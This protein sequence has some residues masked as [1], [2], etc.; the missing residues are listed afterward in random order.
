MPGE[1]MAG[2]RDDRNVARPLVHLQAPGCFPAIHARQRQVHQ[3]DVGKE[4]DRFLDRLETVRRFGDAISGKLQIR[5]VH[6][7]RILVVLD[8]K[9][10]RL[11]GLR[12]DGHR[13]RHPPGYGRR[14]DIT[15]K[16]RSSSQARAGT[17]LG[18]ACPGRLTRRRGRPDLSG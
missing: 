1:R 13:R 10:E 11:N 15:P 17:R 3:D 18:P 5:G 7:A 16:N 2:Q 4:F 14:P 8:D 12:H 9:H 6:F